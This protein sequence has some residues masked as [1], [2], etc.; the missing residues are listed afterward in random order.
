MSAASRQA[1]LARQGRRRQN[2]STALQRSTPAQHAPG[3][4]GGPRT[5]PLCFSTVPAPPPCCA[6]CTAGCSRSSSAR[7]WLPPAAGLPRGRPSSRRASC[8]CCRCGACATAEP[9][10]RANRRCASRA[11]RCSA[12]AAA[13]W[14]APT[15]SASSDVSPL[16][17][18]RSQVA[19][20]GKRATADSCAGG[21]CSCPWR[22]TTRCAPSWMAAGVRELEECG[23]SRAEEH[24]Q[25][26]APTVTGFPAPPMLLPASLTRP[27]SRAHPACAPPTPPCRAAAPAA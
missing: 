4:A 24:R 10:S 14:G 23:I 17:V 27:A 20:S 21:F 9:T 13:S 1:R 26:Q 12:C 18:G 6:A 7:R 2:G 3:G 25:A 5:L 22:A 19:P 15:C 11:A 16:L 8:C